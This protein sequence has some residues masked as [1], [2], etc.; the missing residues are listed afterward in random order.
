MEDSESWCAVRCTEAGHSITYIA[1]FH[2]NL[3]FFNFMI[4]ETIPAAKHLFQDLW[5]FVQGLRLTRMINILL[6]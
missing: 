5:L 2:W 6:L 1:L 4:M 3:S